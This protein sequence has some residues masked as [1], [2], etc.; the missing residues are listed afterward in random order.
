MHRLRDG[1]RRHQIAAELRKNDAYAD[2][3]GLVAGAAN[4][5]QPACDRRR[6]LDLHDQIDRAHV[7]AE[8]ERRGRDERAEAPGFEQIFDLDALEPRERSVVR[9]HERFAR[10]LVE[11]PRQTLG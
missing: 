9:A 10:E 4:A 5:L 6:R 3:V 11:R 2:R 7:D 8:L 1:G